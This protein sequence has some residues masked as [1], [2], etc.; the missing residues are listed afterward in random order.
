MLQQPVA[1][2]PAANWY[3]AD[4]FLAGLRRVNLFCGGFGSGKTEV[5]VNFALHL[6]AASRRVS[7]ADLDIVN[8]YFRSREV[9]DIMRGRGIDV[10]VP[11]EGMIDADMPV[12]QPEIQ[13]ALAQ[14]PGVVVLDLGGD[15]V[16]ARVMASM[17]RYLRPSDCSGM[18]VLN[19][20]RPFTATAAGALRMMTDI[21]VASGVGINRVVV[22]SHLID[23]TSPEVIGEGIALAEEVCAVGGAEIAF[24]AVERRMLDRF[25]A[26]ACRYPAM[27]M[28][29]FML[30]PWRI[31][32]RLGKN[33]FRLS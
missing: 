7:I 19:S 15:P 20:R 14:S 31:S 24:V 25:D 30:P 5:A 28:D 13:G 8:P 16:G 26:A 21:G 23:E 33:R 4:R 1:V 3:N 12:V 27:V 32:E 6:A 10:L 29:R 11:R 2:E 17:V 9:R 22:N 18:L